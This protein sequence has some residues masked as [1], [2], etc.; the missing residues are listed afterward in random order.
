MTGHSPA[1][2][3]PLRLG[4]SQRLRGMAD[5]PSS[6]GTSEAGR[7]GYALGVT[8]F[9]A[10]LGWDKRTLRLSNFLMSFKT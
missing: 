9:A 10:R 5:K 3:S 7:D 8:V 2:S 1:S 4:R 6:E